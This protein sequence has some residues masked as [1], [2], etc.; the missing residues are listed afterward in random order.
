MKG[1]DKIRKYKD[2]IFKKDLPK[3]TKEEKLRW[4]LFLILKIINSKNEKK[5]KKILNDYKFELFSHP[6]V[7]YKM[8]QN[9][10]FFR[11]LEIYK[12]EYYQENKGGKNPKM[13]YKQMILSVIK[14]RQLNKEQKNRI[15]WQ[16][17]NEFNISKL[18]LYKFLINQNKVKWSIDFFELNNF[19]ILNSSSVT[20]ILSKSFYKSITFFWLL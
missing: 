16:I 14:T 6:V 20:I 1:L 8:I 9:R 11:F 13:F 5:L 10:F 17:I 3:I 7:V 2:D 18:L 19:Q 12:K 4:K 15:L